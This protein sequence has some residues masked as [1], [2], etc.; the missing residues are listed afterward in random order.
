MNY[1][2]YSKINAKVYEKLEKFS[3]DGWALIILGIWAFF[4]ASF[5]FIAP[6]FIIGVL[7]FFAPKRYKKFL[8]VTIVI[9]LIGG[10]GYYLFVSIYPELAM[11]ILSQTPFLTEKSMG[12]VSDYLGKGVSYTLLQSFTFIQFK[13]WTYFANVYGL[14]IIAYFFLV[15]ISRIIRFSVV[16]G[17]AILLSKINKKFLKKNIILLILGYVLFIIGFLW[18]FET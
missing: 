12:F 11:T 4:E 15:G 16:A 2:N 7:C 8:G 6:D 14:N 5:W 18:Y 9:S 3:L 17:I 13:A 1:L 10:L